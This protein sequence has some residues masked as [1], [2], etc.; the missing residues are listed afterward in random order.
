MMLRVVPTFQA[1]HTPLQVDPYA[2]PA[3]A[4]REGRVPIG[5]VGERT[6]PS[7]MRTS[8]FTLRTGTHLAGA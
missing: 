8:G 7:P 4:L 3:E 6:R 5:L 1:L 2:V